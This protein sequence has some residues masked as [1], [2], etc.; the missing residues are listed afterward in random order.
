[1]YVWDVS[2]DGDRVRLSNRR[3]V[4]DSEAQRLAI[5]KMVRPRVDFAML[6]PSHGREQI[7]AFSVTPRGYNFPYEGTTIPPVTAADK[8]ASGLY[9]ARIRYPRPVPP[10][11]QFD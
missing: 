3:V 11:W 7:V 6:F 1:M 4:F 5:R 8:T 2:P 9:F 10:A